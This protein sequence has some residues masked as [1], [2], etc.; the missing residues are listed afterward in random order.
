[1]LR[2]T[3][4]NNNFQ[5][6]H[7]RH[8]EIDK[9]KWDAC[10]ES[11]HNCLIYA[12]SWYLDIVSP[13]W[14]ALVLGDYEVVMPLPVKRKYGIKYVMQPILSQQLGIFSKEKITKEFVE[15]FLTTAANCYGVIRLNLNYA[16]QQVSDRFNS[17]NMNNYILELD[18]NKNLYRTKF[19][20]S[21]LRNVKLAE[22]RELRFTEEYNIE[23]F[24]RFVN[25]YNPFKFSTKL[26]PTVVNLL[27]EIKHRKLGFIYSVYSKSNERLAT[28]YVIDYNNRKTTILST[29]TPQGRNSMANY[30]L[31]DVFFKMQENSNTLIDFEGSNIKGI[32]DFFQG[33]GAM[34]QPYTF[35]SQGNPLITLKQF[36]TGT[37]R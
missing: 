33:F 15:V 31:F 6:K 16:N 36:L 18:E 26:S 7:L 2:F 34:N 30:Y 22:G 9:G 25:T 3:E 32:A 13:N 19:K 11:S 4:E 12:L 5:P 17:S 10:I 37:N 29:Q 24:F 28:V 21:V 35:I 8:Q 14:E 1:M 23:D 20:R 27:S